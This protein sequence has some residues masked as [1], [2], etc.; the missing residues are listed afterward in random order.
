ML[1]YTLITQYAHPERVDLC[2]GALSTRAKYLCQDVIKVKKARIHRIF[3]PQW[4]YP[5]NSNEIIRIFVVPC[6]M[7][8]FHFLM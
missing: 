3:A 4:E 5:Q 6:A 8:H 2:P 1:S 7:C